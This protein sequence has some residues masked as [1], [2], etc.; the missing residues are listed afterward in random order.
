MTGYGE[1]ECGRRSLLDLATRRF[2]RWIRV[3][4]LL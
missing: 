3:R 1:V 4:F 2:L